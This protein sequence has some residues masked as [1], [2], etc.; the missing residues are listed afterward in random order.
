MVLLISKTRTEEL[1]YDARISHNM[2][3]PR[4][5]NKNIDA[6]SDFEVILKQA[7]DLVQR[8]TG[9]LWTDYNIH[10][11]GITLLEQ[12]CFALTDLHYKT[13]LS[14][15]DI[16][17]NT[18]GLINRNQHAFFEKE[19]ILTCNPVTVND[20][21][22]VILDKVKEINN[23]MFNPVLSV[24]SN[25]YI[26]GLYR[27]VVRANET[28][29]NQFVTDKEAEEEFKE[30]IRK[31]TLS[32]RNIC[33]DI[34]GDIIIL[35]CQKITIHA[36][37]NIKYTS[38][39]EEIL[40]RIYNK[41]ESI[42]NPKIRF[43]SKSELLDM[44]YTTEQIYNGPLLE[45]GV[46]LEKEL[47]PI[48]TEIDPIDVTNAITILDGVSYIQN[49]TIEDTDDFDVVDTEVAE[50]GK[51]E[52]KDSFPFK[53]RKDHFA[54]L[55]KDTFLKNVKLYSDDYRIPINEALFL[56]LY[57]HREPLKTQV[58][59][60]YANKKQARNIK[61]GTYKDV[62]TYYSIQNYF[63]AIYGLGPNGLSK[64]ETKERKAVAKQLKAYLLFFEQIL[65]NY[66]AQLANL[67]NLYS[68]DLSSSNQKSYYIQD[69][70][71]VPDIRDI[72]KEYNQNGDNRASFVDEMKWEKFQSDEDNGYMKA[73]LKAVET[74][75]IYTDR[76]NRI[77]DHL[78]GRFNRKLSIYPILQYFNS[79]IG[80]SSLERDTFVLQWKANILNHLLHIDQGK[81][82][83]YDYSSQINLMSG[84]EYKI[85]LY[86][87]VNHLEYPSVTKFK[88]KKESLMRRRLTNAFNNTEKKYTITAVKPTSTVQEEQ[89]ID[90][91]EFNDEN[92]TV[93]TNSA[94]NIELAENLEADNIDQSYI[95]SSQTIS[96]LEFGI[97]RENYKIIP[98]DGKYIIIYKPPQKDAITP[99]EKWQVIGSYKIKS[100]AISALNEVIESL[101]KL[102]VESEGFHLVEH[103]LMRPKLDQHNFGF[104]YYESADSVFFKNDEWT[105]FEER[106][107]RLTKLKNAVLNL[108]RTTAGDDFDF[109]VKFMDDN[110]FSIV[111]TSV[112]SKRK[113]DL[114]PNL[115]KVIA[116]INK[117]QENKI[118]RYP[119]IELNA[120]LSG[121]KVINENFY[122]LKATVVLPAWP[123]RFQDKEFKMFTE[124]LIKAIA[125]GYLILNFKWLGISRMQ[126]FENL[127]FEWLEAIK[128]N[129]DPNAR[130]ESC[131]ALTNWLLETDIKKQK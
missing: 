8:L 16:L 84:F 82:K 77:L 27:I 119:R 19:H 32:K 125:P 12:L 43:Y 107:K 26:K 45:N 112:F 71:N 39:P 61:A 64:S 96:V 7:I 50:K 85:S 42:L 24:H 69:L 129:S 57:E 46:L 68:T 30:K 108:G 70:Y 106:E 104:S 59:K 49:L 53:L 36:N 105:S 18:R 86:L 95:F 111:N 1:N 121:R 17:T 123:A 11:P 55:E 40:L 15:E 51:V 126:K 41:I 99:E 21:R 35:K 33:E 2:I 54:Y 117:M 38:V 52:K 124:D 128:T 23:I 22:K 122:S 94:E 14:T 76:K 83:G 80:G 73:L 93:V 31:L 28:I 3:E 87:N 65:A 20:F 102:S 66:S 114:N 67:G 101:K 75:E 100:K 60:E 63:P 25:H 48:A 91:I 74:P 110:H 88:S 79:Y 78:L 37:I 56:E 118:F 109:K 29:T 120:K 90:I 81:I 34:M 9:H 5:I 113:Q 103:L 97:M 127:Y 44:G 6:V 62:G 89:E 13:T 131:E 4:F 10:D 92:L 72:L 116:E 58:R 115:K 98:K 47:K 130:L